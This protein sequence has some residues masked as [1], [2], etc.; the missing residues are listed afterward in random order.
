MRYFFLGLLL[1][2][3]AVV[4]L[5][6]FRGHRFTVAQ[7]QIIQ[8]MDNQPKMKAQ[9][10][11]K[12]FADGRSAR[13]PVAGTVSQAGYNE[14]EYFSTGKI[15]GEWGDGI[16]IKIDPAKMKRGRERYTIYCSVCH[17]ATGSGNGFTTEYGMAGVANFNSDRLRQLPDGKIFDTIT[18]GMPLMNNYA[19]QITPEDRWAVIAYVRALQR[20]EHASLDDVPADKKGSLNPY[21]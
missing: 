18:H 4:A 5:L 21:E 9:S 1:F 3:I 2:V 7:I 15:N 11:S 8:D 20:A 6:G 19:A 14:D 16:A 13:T 12:F 17:G 10:I